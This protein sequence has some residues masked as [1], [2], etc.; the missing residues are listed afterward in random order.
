M[1]KITSGSSAGREQ[2]KASCAEAE[3]IYVN[4]YLFWG[5]DREANMTFDNKTPVE[6]WQRSRKSDSANSEVWN[7]SFKWITGKV[8]Q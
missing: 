2:Q 8:G 3:R 1:N 7:F 5:Y 4:E 6:G